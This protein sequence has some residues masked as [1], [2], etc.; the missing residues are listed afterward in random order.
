MKGQALFGVTSVFLVA[1]FGR[2]CPT[3]HFRP[4]GPEAILAEVRTGV[5]EGKARPQL[6]ELCVFGQNEHLQ[7][8]LLALPVHPA[9]L[10]RVGHIAGVLSLKKLD[11]AF[12][13]C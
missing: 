4:R 2:P 13:Q 7:C 5:P 6:Q 3:E 1:R 11:V 8:L 10:Q 9:P 12:K